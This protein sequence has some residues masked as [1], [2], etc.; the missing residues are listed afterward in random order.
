MIVIGEDQLRRLERARELRAQAEK[1]CAAAIAQR[2]L[3]LSNAVT[4][5]VRLDRIERELEEA[6]VRE[7][8]LRKAVEEARRFGESIYEVTAWGLR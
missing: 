4:L 5:Q 2:E 8:R 3:A 6:R 1:Q 7:R